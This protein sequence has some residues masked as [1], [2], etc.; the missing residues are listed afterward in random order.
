MFNVKEQK[1]V[2]SQLDALGQ[3]ALSCEY[4]MVIHGYE[5]LMVLTKGFALPVI[6]PEEKIDVPIVGGIMTHTQA[7]PRTEFSHQLTM[8]ETVEG[9]LTRFHEEL[10]KGRAINNR[11]TFSFTV[12]MGSPEKHTYKWE[13]THGILFGIE[14]PEID[15]ENRTGLMMFNG[16]IAYHCFGSEKGN[17]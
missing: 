11:P 8:Y 7:L 14:P 12:Y 1:R 4:S 5:G 17:I 2:I 9:H 10:A 16:Q 13:C 15:V 6:A 3:F